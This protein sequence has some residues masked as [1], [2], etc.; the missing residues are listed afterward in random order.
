MNA[1]ASEDDS[2]DMK[3]VTLRN[4]NDPCEEG[5]SLDRGHSSDRTS[6]DA[7]GSPMVA[8]I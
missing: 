5:M 6:N 1:I 7:V 2:L 4:R 8:V 3:M